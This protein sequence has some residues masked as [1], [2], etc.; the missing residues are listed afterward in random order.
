MDF[1][2]YKNVSKL[3]DQIADMKYGS[4]EA[5]MHQFGV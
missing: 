3:W 1:L 4:E 5:K 2:V